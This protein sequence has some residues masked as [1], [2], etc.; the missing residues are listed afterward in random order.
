MKVVAGVFSRGATVLA[1]RR[2]P[3]KT[4]AGR[5]EFPGGK[6]EPDE[7]EPTALR[8]ELRE[9]FGIEVEVDSLLDRTTS[10]VDG[11]AIT[12]ACYRVQTA[13]PVPDHGVDHDVI[14]WFDRR[15]LPWLDWADPDRAVA[16]LIAHS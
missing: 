12:L 3:G 16:W 6:L 10:L 11:I 5:W 15:G 1:C 13:D 7:D 9:E 4:S 8:R 14:A 2:R